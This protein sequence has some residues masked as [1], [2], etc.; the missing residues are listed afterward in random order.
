VR[1]I[2]D[3]VDPGVAATGLRRAFAAADGGGRGSQ[4]A[5]LDTPAPWRGV[6]PGG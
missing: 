5:L 3:A 4:D 6:A 1:A 2:R